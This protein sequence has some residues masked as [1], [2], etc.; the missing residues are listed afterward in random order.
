MYTL[1]HLS[2]AEILFYT[3]M[4]LAIALGLFYCVIVVIGVLRLLYKPPKL[5]PKPSL[6]L[7]PKP[8]TKPTID[9]QGHQLYNKFGFP[10]E[11]ED[12]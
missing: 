11:K 9:K 3:S 1:S 12:E 6:K 10:L 4:C 8:S 2:A 7:V 5:K